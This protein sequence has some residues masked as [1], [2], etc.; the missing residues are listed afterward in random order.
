[1]WYHGSNGPVEKLNIEKGSGMNLWGSRG[2]YLSRDKRVAAR[3]GPC[4][5]QFELGELSVLETDAPIS[6]HDYSKVMGILN[7]HV[8]FMTLANADIDTYGDAIVLAAD[9]GLGQRENAVQAFQEALGFDALYTRDVEGTLNGENFSEGDVLV[10]LAAEKSRFIRSDYARLPPNVFFHGSRHDHPITQFK[11]GKYPAIS[12]FLGMPTQEVDRHAFFFST[13]PA[14]AS[15]YGTV[16]AYALPEGPILDIRNDVKEEDAQKLKEVGIETRWIDNLASVDKWQIFDGKDGQELA[17]VIKQL[18]YKGV[19]YLEVDDFGTLRHCRAIV[20]ENLPKHIPL[21]NGVMSKLNIIVSAVDDLREQ[22][23]CNGHMGDDSVLKV[24]VQDLLYEAE[25]EAD[26]P[27]VIRSLKRGEVELLQEQLF[28]WNP[29]IPETPEP[30][31]EISLVSQ[32]RAKVG[33]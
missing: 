31:P 21:P 23:S 27:T 6:D 25:L 14:M 4:I 22:Y 12:G 15:E 11:H 9:Y 10:L 33:I 18:G 13:I 19:D 1:M 7:K 16:H 29:Y 32:L 8:P 28:V 20:D 2:A 26:I 17:N 30:A 5:N 3:F 24:M